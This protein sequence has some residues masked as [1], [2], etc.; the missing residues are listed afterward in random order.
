MSEYQRA[1]PAAAIAA[2]QDPQITMIL[3][4]YRNYGDMI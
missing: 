4:L 1:L 2:L 3:D